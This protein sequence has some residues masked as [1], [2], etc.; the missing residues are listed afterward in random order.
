MPDNIYIKTHDGVILRFS[1][2]EDIRRWIKEGRIRENDFIKGEG[3]VWQIVKYD[4]RFADL[5]GGRNSGKTVSPSKDEGITPL[6]AEKKAS[7]KNEVDSD[8]WGSSPSDTDEFEKRKSRLPV[9]LLIILSIVALAIAGFFIY[10]LSMAPVTGAPDAAQYESDIVAANVKEA[11]DAGFD[12][13]PEMAVREAEDAAAEKGVELPAV[14][15]VQVDSLP[16]AGAPVE[17]ETGQT[18][19][20][21]AKKSTA[22]K[23]SDERDVQPQVKKDSK[24]AKGDYDS[25]MEKGNSLIGS[26]PEKA[27]PVFQLAA[28]INPNRAEP[29]AKIGFCHL[30]MGNP[31]EAAVSFQRALVLNVDFSP[32]YIGLARSHKKLGNGMEARMNYKEYLKRNPQGQYAGEAKSYLADE[33]NE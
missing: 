6:W 16:E 13:R 2:T 19:E 27:I 3:D 22:G 25:L 1:D 7:D 11:V 32:A 30:N 5:F 15:D 33:P 8:V 18:A 24:P 29:F 10:T 14:Q 23:V 4:D 12:M 17:V 26:E 21:T 9:I 28:Q 20:T 31:K